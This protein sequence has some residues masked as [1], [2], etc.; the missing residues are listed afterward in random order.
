MF[1]ADAEVENTTLRISEN[2]NTNNF[3]ID[4]S[5]HIFSHKVGCWHIVNIKFYSFI[6]EHNRIAAPCCLKRMCSYTFS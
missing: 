5:R 3:F 6:F 2:K 1:T 4:S